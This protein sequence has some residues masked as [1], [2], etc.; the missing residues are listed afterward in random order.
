MGTFGKRCYYKSSLGHYE[1]GILKLKEKFD[2]KQTIKLINAKKTE[3]SFVC[4]NRITIIRE[5]K[6]FRSKHITCFI[7]DEKKIYP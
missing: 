1:F 4:L 5:T 2:R 6:I 7:K 3:E